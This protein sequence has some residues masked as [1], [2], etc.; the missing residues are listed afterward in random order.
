MSRERDRNSHGISELEEPG[1]GHHPGS[2]STG[3]TETWRGRGW[4]TVPPGCAQWSLCPPLPAQTAP[5][6]SGLGVRE[7]QPAGWV[8]GSLCASFLNDFDFE[9][10]SD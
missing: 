6:A 2:S 3:E 4:F 10:I 1:R 5:P 9:S 7:P 8:S